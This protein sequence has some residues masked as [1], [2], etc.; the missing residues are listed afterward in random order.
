MYAEWNSVASL[1]Q[2]EIN[3][4]LDAK[5]GERRQES[6][7]LKLNRRTFS[8][9]LIEEVIRRDS[10]WSSLRTV[11]RDFTMI[12]WHFDGD[13]LT[14]HFDW[15]AVTC[16]TYYIPQYSDMIGGELVFND[17]GMEIRPQTGLT[18]MFP[19]GI[20]HST[21]KAICKS[22]SGRPLRVSMIQFGLVDESILIEQL[23][24][25]DYRK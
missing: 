24:S 7:S 16:V 3:V 4:V 8:R 19:G 10:A 18:V 23:K 21:K 11:S 22:G 9:E 25:V 12:S 14:P 1:E 5:Y 13:L 15:V 17:Y 2:G 20:N 6:L